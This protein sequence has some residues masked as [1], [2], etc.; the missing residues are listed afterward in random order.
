[1]NLNVTYINKKARA[2]C[3]GSNSLREKNYASAAPSSPAG[4]SPSTA[5]A[6]SSSSSAAPPG[7]AILAITKSRSVQLL[8]AYLLAM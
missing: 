4:V 7:A 1:M 5:S 3:T 2:N 6:T 8:G